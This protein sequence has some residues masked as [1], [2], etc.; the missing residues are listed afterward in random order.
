M[1]KAPTD[2]ISDEISNITHLASALMSLGDTEIY[3]KTYE[4]VVRSVRASGDV[5]PDW[6]PPSAHVKYEYKWVQA[7]DGQTFGPYGEEE[8]NAWFKA[9]YFGSMGEKVKVRKVGGE[10]GDWDEIV[11]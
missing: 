9:A 2:P 11:S 5:E 6:E 3:S 10:W 7:T 1:E 8:L 4:Q